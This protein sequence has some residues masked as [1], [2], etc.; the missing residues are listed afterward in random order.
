MEN[1]L[2][3][4]DDRLRPFNLA[5]KIEVSQSNLP[6]IRSNA[7]ILERKLSLTGV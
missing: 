2:D 1:N 6:M 3:D 4:H 7:L 5:D